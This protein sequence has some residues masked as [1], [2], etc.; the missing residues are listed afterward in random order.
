M[1]A[2]A[3]LVIDYQFGGFKEAGDEEEKL[4]AI[5]KNIVTGNKAV[6]NYQ[7]DM[8]ERRGEALDIKKMKFRN[9]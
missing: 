8:K 7:M 9:N 2:R 4:A 1:K 5:L 6:A 3:V